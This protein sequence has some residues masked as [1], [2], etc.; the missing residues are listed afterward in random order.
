M[1]SGNIILINQQGNTTSTSINLCRKYYNTSRSERFII[2]HIPIIHRQQITE[3]FIV[4]GATDL[5]IVVRVQ[6]K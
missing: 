1:A 3:K 4:S 2:I 5:I 6:A